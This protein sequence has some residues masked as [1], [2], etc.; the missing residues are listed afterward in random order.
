MIV[1]CGTTTLNTN[2]TCRIT[3][4]STSAASSFSYQFTAATC[5]STLVLEYTGWT[6]DVC[7]GS[8]CFSLK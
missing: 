8:A 4:P 1:K 6:N 3:P 5:A 2:T 7:G